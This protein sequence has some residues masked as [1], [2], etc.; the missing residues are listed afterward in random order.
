MTKEW[1]L[2][3]LVVLLLAASAFFVAAEFSLI[4]ARRTV[5]EPMAVSSA[6]ARATLKAMENVS[7][8]M[9]CAQLGITLCGVLLGA[10]GEPAA[11]LNSFRGTFEVEGNEYVYPGRGLALYVDPAADMP[12]RGFR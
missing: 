11:R 10:L 8:M 3:L 12:L 5:I 4:A 7:E 1:L 6:R 2:L 9:A